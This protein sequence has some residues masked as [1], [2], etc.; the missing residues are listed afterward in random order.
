M[1]RKGKQIA[2]G[3]LFLAAGFLCILLGAGAPRVGA[4]AYSYTDADFR[5]TS[6]DVEMSVASDR[7][8][9][10]A[11]TLEVQFLDQCHGI[12]LDLPL[13]RGVRYKNVKSLRDGQSFSTHSEN[14]RSDL[15]SVYLG[16]R[17]EPMAAGETHVY[18]ITYVMTV[19]ALE[20]AGYL[21]LDVLGMDWQ[22]P[23]D[24][25]TARV[26]FP[27]GLE[28]YEVHR[29]GGSFFADDYSESREGN[30]ISLGVASVGYGYGITLDLIF[31]EDALTPPPFDLTPLWVVLAGMGLFA[32]LM[33]VK[34]FY[35][36]NAMITRMVNFTAPDEMDPLKMGNIIDNK[37][38]AEDLGALIFWFAS[39]GYLKID[40]R[41][42]NKENPRL[43]ATNKPL[44]A[45]LPAYLVRYY[46]G[47]F[48]EGVTKVRMNELSDRFYLTANSV[49]QQV[50]A[51]SGDLYTKRSIALIVIACLF[52]VLLSGGFLTLFSM[53]YVGQYYF[54]WSPIAFTA[55]SAA[56][57]AAATSVAVMR[58]Y[59]WRPAKRILLVLGGFL[60]GLVPMLFLGIFAGEC[61]AF[62]KLPVY[63]AIAVADLLGAFSG[64][65]LTRTDAYSATLGKIL[66]FKDFLTYTEKDRIE[67]LLEEEPELFYR[68]LPYAQVLG[69]TEKWTEK[70]EGLE[71]APPAYYNGGKV[72]FTAVVWNSM[73]RNLNVRIGTVLTT[74]PSNRGGGFSGSSGGGH[75][76]GGFGGGGGRSF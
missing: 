27:E 30:T 13:D 69:V 73:F 7:R 9:A 32:L 1:K 35:C 46:R 47:L 24:R 44:P 67:A 37:V 68:L 6:F 43:I 8:I 64:T 71:L 4:S 48:P 51:A 23:I 74:R 55:I 53:F 31:A 42:E 22:A 10:V 26:T 12:I 45:G 52:A 2:A 16:S 11:E 21:P 19:P 59:K 58:H 29:G 54:H 38:D 18:T 3:L 5:I 14:D 75:V 50:R 40:A 57:A 41:G 33:I 60:L 65:M 72:L 61:A 36:R 20:E 49:K 56:I 34:T 63:L 66:G 15:L 25:F 17:F 28:R 39:N 76:G 62:G 70:F